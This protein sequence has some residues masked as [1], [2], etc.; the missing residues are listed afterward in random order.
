MCSNSRIIRQRQS[1][2]R[3]ELDRRGV[4]MKAVAMD[5]SI[6]YPTLLTYFPQDRDKEPAQIPGGAIFSLLEGSAI[7]ADLMSLL[8]PEGWQVVKVPEGVDHGEV[9]AAMHDYLATKSAAHAPDSP[10][11]PAI[12]A[13]EDG[14]LKAKLAAVPA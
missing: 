11:G 8:M 14:V 12:S 9:A 6:P 5:A 3:R 4:S 7:P 1:A 10:A 2:I 13:C